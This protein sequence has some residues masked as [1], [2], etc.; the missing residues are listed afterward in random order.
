MDPT[1]CVS[2][3]VINELKQRTFITITY[4]NCKLACVAR[5]ELLCL[6]YFKDG[7]EGRPASTQ[8]NCKLQLFPHSLVVVLSLFGGGWGVGR[9]VS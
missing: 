7:H 5:V 9:I 1:L 2:S 3:G 6:G 8:A 4:V